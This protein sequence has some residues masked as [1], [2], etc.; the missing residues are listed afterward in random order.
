[1]D[2]ITWRPIAEYFNGEHDWVLV[3]MY[4]G[5]YPCIPCVAEYN[6]KDGKWHMNDS[7]YTV[8]PFPAHEFFDMSTIGPLPEQKEIF[9][10]SYD[11]MLVEKHP[12][13]SGSTDTQ[14][15]DAILKFAEAKQSRVR[16]MLAKYVHYNDDFRQKLIHEADTLGDVLT[17]ANVLREYEVSPKNHI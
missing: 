4:D 10:G 6:R 11:A 8:L 15:L 17:L 1:M 13:S 7:E 2:K 16:D 14:I 5:E 3:R 9:S 12:E